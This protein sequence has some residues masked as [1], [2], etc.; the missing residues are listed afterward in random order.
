MINERRPIKK[1]RFHIYFCIGSLLIGWLGLLI[2]GIILNFSPPIAVTCFI[3]PM[4]IGL[5]DMMVFD[6]K[7][8]KKISEHDEEMLLLVKKMFLRDG[9]EDC[10]EDTRILGTDTIYDITLEKRDDQTKY[11]VR[12]YTMDSGVILGEYGKNIERI[13]NSLKYSVLGYK[14]FV[15]VTKNSCFDN[16]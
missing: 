14:P 8:E 9:R 3:V 4:V 2:G 12:I 6:P 1:T 11:A 15:I 13:Q 10:P 5:I 16:L 7:H